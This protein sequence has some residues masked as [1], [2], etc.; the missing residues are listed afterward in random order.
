MLIL[1]P[2]LK[3]L[4]LF[5]SAHKLA[6]NLQLK[7]KRYSGVI[8]G[9]YYLLLLFA[10]NFI[11]LA[12]TAPFRQAKFLFPASE[13]ATFPWPPALQVNRRLTLEKQ[14]KAKMTPVTCSGLCCFMTPGTTCLTARH[15]PRGG[16]E[17]IM[18][19]YFLPGSVFQPLPFKTTK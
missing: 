12:R 4:S 7:W 11:S 18:S 19:L 14:I 15:L 16:Y 2:A 1:L 6:E 8:S 5:P 9:F 13:A 17:G 3:N 10:A